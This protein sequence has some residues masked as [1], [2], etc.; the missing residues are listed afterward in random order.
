MITHHPAT[1]LYRESWSAVNPNGTVIYFA[2]EQ[3]AA[4]TLDLWA[5]GINITL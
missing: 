2:S 3:D 4:D 1:V 5:H